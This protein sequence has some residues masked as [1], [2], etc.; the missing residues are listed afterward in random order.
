MKSFVSK[1]RLL[2]IAF[3]A[4]LAT[5]SAGLVSG[6]AP[7][8]LGTAAGLAYSAPADAAISMATATRNARCTAIVTA[9]GSGAQL[10]IYSGTRPASANAAVTGTLLATV[11]FGTTIGSCTSGVLDFDEA[12]ASQTSSA[13]V[14]GTPGYARLVTSGA[15]AIYDIDVCGSAPCWAF[16]GTV[17]TNQNVTLTTL[18]LTEGN[19]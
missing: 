16:T 2:A 13:H 14:S 19:S 18:T 11:T 5:L 9:A 6:P 17:A 4:A 12:G 1:F 3:F 8:L 15:T 7:L 10:R